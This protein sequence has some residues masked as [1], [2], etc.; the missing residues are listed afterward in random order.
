MNYSSSHHIAANVMFLF[1]SAL[2][3]SFLTA[4]LKEIERAEADLA[5]KLKNTPLPTKRKGTK[6]ARI[7]K[8][9][10]DNEVSKVLGERKK[11]TVAQTALKKA[12]ALAKKN[13]EEA[14]SEVETIEEDKLLAATEPGARRNLFTA[15]GSI[16]EKASNTG[17]LAHTHA[18]DDDELEA[19]A[20]SDEEANSN[21]DAVMDVL[22][23]HTE[24][25]EN[26]NCNSESEDDD[27]QMGEPTLMSYS[28]YCVYCI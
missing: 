7:G 18:L 9:A 12:S 10:S 25:E 8:R 22:Q 16:T 13:K 26:D 11:L 4:N 2:I 24:N 6:T 5:D 17:S 14:I 19:D 27:V 20:D 23:S 3:L 21:D 28:E 1:L 15:D